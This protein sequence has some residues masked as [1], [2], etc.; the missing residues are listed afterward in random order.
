MD[1]D[2]YFSG[3]DDDS[4]WTQVDDATLPGQGDGAGQ[5]DDPANFEGIDNGDGSYTDPTTWEIYDYTTGELLGWENGDGSWTNLDGQT[6]DAEG[7]PI[8][9][10]IDTLPIDDVSGNG[11]LDGLS[12]FFKSI[13]GGNGGA[14]GGG[15]NFGG[16]SQAQAKQQEQ[17]AQN[18]L[19]Q[20]QQQGASPATISALQRQLSLA[21]QALAATRSGDAS[22]LFMIAGIVG[23]GVYALTRNRRD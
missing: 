5:S 13:F 22:Q 2:D 3:G 7:N 18:R 1:W 10:P 9:L 8:V 21:Q 15:G 11:F 14:P 6:L 23:L 17:A 4:G 20:A 19:N 16:G 12:S